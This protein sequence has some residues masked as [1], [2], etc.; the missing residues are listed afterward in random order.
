MNKVYRVTH[1]GH[2]TPPKINEHELISSTER[3]VTVVSSSPLR[4]D[5]NKGDRYN[6][7]AQE[8]SMCDTLEEATTLCKNILLGRIES[9]E[10]QLV[11]AKRDLKK[12]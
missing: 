5:Q 6:R 8:H 12:F 11:A 1:W 10:G 3:T 4:R 7:D 2:H 9:L